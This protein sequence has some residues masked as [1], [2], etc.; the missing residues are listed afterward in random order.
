MDDAGGMQKLLH[1]LT[2]VLTALIAAEALTLEVCRCHS[3]MAAQHGFDVGL[4][5]Y[6]DNNT[7]TSGIINY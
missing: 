5:T 1:S 6:G 2:G 7:K 3:Q 4:L